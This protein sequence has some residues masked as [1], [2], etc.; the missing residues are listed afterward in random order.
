MP[1]SKTKR[2]SSLQ[3]NITGSTFSYRLSSARRLALEA[4]RS[5]I[6]FIEASPT[7]L[8]QCLQST[9]KAIPFLC[10]RRSISIRGFFSL[11]FLRV[12]KSNDL[13]M[14]SEKASNS[15]QS[16]L[17]EAFSRSRANG[18]GR[19]I[20][21]LGCRE[22][23]SIGLSL[24]EVYTETLSRDLSEKPVSLGRKAVNSRL[25][26]LRIR[27]E[28]KIFALQFTQSPADVG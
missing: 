5:L 22:P 23:I 3:V 6:A 12:S 10:A 21:S 11:K 18:K 15:F 13:K 2:D 28:H 8:F 20:T 27:A 4:C 1:F 25:G 7:V 14:Q 24:P 17:D 16:W 19:K 26:I 9:A